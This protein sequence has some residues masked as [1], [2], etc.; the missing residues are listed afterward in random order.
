MLIYFTE[1]LQYLYQ[2]GFDKDMHANCIL[3]VCNI[4]SQRTSKI[5]SEISHDLLEEMKNI[6]YLKPKGRPPY[7]SRLIR[8]ALMQR[9][10]S[11]QAY[12]QILE[13]LPLPSFSLLQ[14]LTRGGSDAIKSLKILLREDKVDRDCMLL[15]D[16]MY[17]Q[18]ASE[19]HGGKFVGKNE[20]GE[21]YNGIVV[22]MVVGLRKSIPYVI[23][24]LPETKVNGKWLSKH[25]EES[26]ETLHGAGF[27]VR[28]I[29]S[30]NHS[31]NVS[32]F[33][34]LKKKIAPNK[35][36]DDLYVYHPSNP[37]KKIYLFY[38]SVHLVKNIRNN[39]LNAKRFIFPAFNFDGFDESISITSG[40]ISWGL[41]HSVYD[42]DICLQANL[43]KAPM[44]T[45]ETLHPGNK[46]QNVQL[47]LNIFYDTTI[48]GLTSYFPQRADAIE[49]SKVINTW[50][51][52]SNSK[53][54]YNKRNKMGHAA[55][56]GDKKPDFFRALADWFESWQNIQASGC[57]K[58][59]LTK[60][61]CSALII[62]LRATAALIEDLLDEEGFD[63]V[64]VARFQS[65]PLERRFSM[66]RQMS[67]GRFLVSL[68]EVYSSEKILSLK[69]L[70]KENIDIL[71]ENIQEVSSFSDKF[72]L[73]MTEISFME[74]EIQSSTLSKD[75]Q[76]V[77]VMI[78]GYIAKQIIK[79]RDCHSCKELLIAKE[80]E[81]VEDNYLKLLSRG[82]LITPSSSLMEH[83]YHCF[84]ILDLTGDVVIKYI[85]D[86]VRA[87]SEHLLAEYS[88]K[89]HFSC[90]L[91]I[92]SGV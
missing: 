15:V 38:D 19:Y 58:F 25:I 76:D 14:K 56:L 80:S 44:L 68:R 33:G 88:H 46:K 85:P 17:L 24:T 52:I 78:G 74:N 63:H 35:S 83:V 2:N 49:F 90:D 45:Y 41:F 5:V 13:E 73:L 39:L 10:T 82:G 57:E 71:E 4:I 23:R 53:M 61:T 66:Y 8:F 47:A 75:S 29:V 32:A 28:G 81:N 77:A 21:L 50:W 55:V 86:N 84:A 3:L 12:S 36:S 18:K 51:I 62:T 69:S 42:K 40:E 54:K 6:Q 31:V 20:D 43:R 92:L 22:F 9:Y 60:Q 79:K 30:D 70:L 26:I 7:S 48:A 37:S 91:H 16:E 89:I 59:T 1:G 27:R 72:Q 34:I 67:G 87:A 65:D 64:L 11:R